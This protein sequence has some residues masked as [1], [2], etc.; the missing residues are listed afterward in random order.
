MIALD[1]FNRM[2][3]AG[4]IGKYAING[5]ERVWKRIDSTKRLVQ[6]LI[7]LPVALATAEAGVERVSS[8]LE[9]AGYKQRVEDD[10][11]IEG[12]EIGVLVAVDDLGMEALDRAIV[13]QI[14]ILNSSGSVRGRILRNE[15]RAALALKAGGKCEYSFVAMLIEDEDVDVHALNK[16]ITRHELH[17]AWRR[18]QKDERWAADI[19]KSSISCAML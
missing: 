17:E 1:V 18:F 12:W 6:I 3:E 11:E 7:S 15:Y 9:E 2:M 16:L 13:R 8:L 4:S 5:V 14:P 10:I 19:F